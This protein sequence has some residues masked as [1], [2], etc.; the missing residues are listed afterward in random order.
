MRARNSILAVSILLC[1]AAS[2]WP[3]S[4]EPAAPADVRIKWTT[5]TI[6]IAVST[7]LTSSAPGMA[8]DSDVAGALQRALR[9]WS[10]ASNVRFVPVSS[11]LQSVS[12]AGEGDGVSLITIAP[13]SE[14]LAMFG[15]SNNAARTRVFYDS[16]T[17]EISEADIAINPFP[18]SAQGTALQFSTDGSPGTY[19]LESTFVHELGH[20][21]GLSHS[22]VIGATMQS[23]QG[24]NGVYGMSA[25]TERTLSDSDR[26][27]VRSIYG[28]CEDNG[29]VEGRIQ[30]SVQGMLMPASGAHVWLEDPNSGRVVASALAASNGHFS[31][32]CIAPGDYRALVEYGDGPASEL[33]DNV[34]AG[35]RVFRSVE[36][37]NHLRVSNEKATALNFVLVPPQN[38]APSLNPRLLGTNGDLSTAPLPAVAGTRMTIYVGGEGIDLVPG[39]GLSFSSPLITVDAASLTLQRSQEG[40]KVISFDVT[41]LPDVAP[42]DY[43]I[44]L[45]SN[46]GE[47]A[48]LVG[49][50]TVLPQSEFTLSKRN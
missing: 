33:R 47:T 7:S 32:Q 24:L 25:L 45:Q 2:G 29:T 21:L 26:V 9:T 22:Q 14:N 28:P 27:A 17:G 50:L 48:Y 42:G 44:R 10:T 40:M 41:L 15:E 6:K 3:S 34:Q 4:F 35:R 20:L 16:V 12:P 19:D 38:S 39:H 18:F 8:P 1:C 49:G 23:A 31:F 13:T 36:I 46:S 37:N 30:N 5:R 43:T 11:K